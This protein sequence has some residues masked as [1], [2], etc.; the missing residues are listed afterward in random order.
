MAITIANGISNGFNT[1]TN[2]TYER[3]YFSSKW[4]RAG[5]ASLSG[6]FTYAENFPAGTLMIV[7]Y[8]HSTLVTASNN[9]AATNPVTD[10][11]GNVYSFVSQNTTTSQRVALAYCTLTNP[12][13]TSTTLTINP[14]T[15]ISGSSYEAIWAVYAIKGEL[16]EFSMS[17]SKVGG[18]A[19]STWTISTGTSGSLAY[20]SGVAIAVF[21][22]YNAYGFAS[23]STTNTAGTLFS[24]I[25]GQRM[26]SNALTYGSRNTLVL[27]YGPV[28]STAHETV[29]ITG[30]SSQTYSA[31]IAHFYQ[32]KP[33]AQ[34]SFG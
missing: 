21:N 30:S 16:L 34:A 13:T 10:S 4:V 19:S 28:T 1:S 8:G 14:T 25:D 22:L 32:R 33:V 17:A 18:T 5:L 27:A 29:T 2:Q 20:G 11:A 26:F 15:A 7:A 23:L 3:A 6:T 24:F 31:I 12:V 9:F